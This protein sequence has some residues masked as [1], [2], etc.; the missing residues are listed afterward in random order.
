M[1]VPLFWWNKS[2]HSA[3]QLVVS[4]GASYR[5]TEKPEW[6]SAP[7]RAC[8]AV[9]LLL[10]EQ[11]AVWKSRPAQHLIFFVCVYV[12][13]YVCEKLTVPQQHSPAAHKIKTSKETKKWYGENSV[14]SPPRLLL[15]LP[16]GNRHD[17][18][19]RFSRDILSEHHCPSIP[20]AS[21][22][23]H[24]ISHNCVFKSIQ[25]YIKN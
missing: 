6:A 11:T 10:S 25:L 7:H 13:V 3:V 8:A 12:C 18:I 1:F 19:L 5:R 9:G 21:K 23:K 14:C 20:F 4:D 15:P 16:R 2:C 22:A 17:S 24:F